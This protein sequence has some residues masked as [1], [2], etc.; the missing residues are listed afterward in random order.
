MTRTGDSIFALA[1][2]LTG[3]NQLRNDPAETALATLAADAEGW[4]VLDAA[5][6][7]GDHDA[8]MI[9]ALGLLADRLVN[10]AACIPARSATAKRDKAKVATI[11]LRPA[12]RGDADI[13]EPGHALLASILSD[14]TEA[15][16]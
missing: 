8:L 4:S 5:P 10:E 12:L 16:A 6:L 1:A 9:E 14:L 11:L 3:A 2:E 15:S 7:S 13:G